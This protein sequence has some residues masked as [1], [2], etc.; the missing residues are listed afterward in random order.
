VI[1]CTPLPTPKLKDSTLSAVRECL[2][3]F[4]LFSPSQRWQFNSVLYETIIVIYQLYSITSYKAEVFV[5]IRCS[6]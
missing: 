1:C 6:I 5:N 3:S 2:F 4:C